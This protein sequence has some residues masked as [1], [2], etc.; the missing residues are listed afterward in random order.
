MFNLT[1][2]KKKLLDK[3][4][5]W[6]ILKTRSWTLKLANVLTKRA[7]E[8]FEAKGG[9]AAWEPNAVAILHWILA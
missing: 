1:L 8:P 3:S 9:A 5:L 2:L 6:D 4:R 7:G